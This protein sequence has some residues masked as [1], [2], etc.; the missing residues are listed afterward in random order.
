MKKIRVCVVGYGNVGR[1]AVACIR[2]APDMEPAGVIRRTVD[3]SPADLPVVT[4]V[5]ELGPVDAAL[6]TIPSRAVPAA[7]PLYLQKGINT[8][9]GY[10]LPGEAIV[11]LRRKLDRYARANGS[12]AVTGAGWDPGTDSVVRLLFAAIAPVGITYTDFGPGMSMGHSAMARAIPGVKDAVAM[13]LPLGCGE[14]R[15]DVYLELEEGASF[16]EIAGKIKE[17]PFFSSGRTEVIRVAD[18]RPYKNRGHGVRI[19]RTGSSG[20]AHNQLLELKMKITN[21]AA[22][23]QVM[24]SA[25]RASMRLRPGSYILGEIPP[26]DLLPESREAIIGKLI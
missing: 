15:R 4:R 3:G 9:D 26:I 23:A 7:A 17:D 16:A 14:H 5:E 25:A 24:I 20:R 21:P 6:L 12:V 11:E 1:E 18:L 2:D 8:V 19:R 10:D 13:T 22:A